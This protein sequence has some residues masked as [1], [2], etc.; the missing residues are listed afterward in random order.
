ELIRP[1]ALA[2]AHQGVAALFV[3]ALLLRS[4][5]QVHE[6]L[7]RR[8]QPHPQA[9]PRRLG[10][11]SGRAGPRVPKLCIAAALS[12]GVAGSVAAARGTLDVGARTFARVDQ[13]CAAQRRQGTLVQISP[14]A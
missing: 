5:P 11:T 3:G 8:R 2:I 12:R 4:V 7:D 13:T 9:T 1:V 14:L 6:P 10:K